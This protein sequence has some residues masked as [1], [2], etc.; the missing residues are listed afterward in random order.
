[1]SAAIT[2]LEHILTVARCTGAKMSGRELHY[3][4]I[5]LK[6]LGYGDEAREQQ[7]R[8]LIQQKSDRILAR[9]ARREA[10]REATP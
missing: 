1:M 3:V 9:R 5:A 6:G 4:E 8:I 7:L 2:A 10:R